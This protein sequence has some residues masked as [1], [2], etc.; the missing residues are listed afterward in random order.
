MISRMLGSGR[1]LHRGQQRWL[2]DEAGATS[3]AAS[4]VVTS[5]RRRPGST[6][7]PLACRLV[8]SGDPEA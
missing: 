2:Q 4:T 6:I 8:D 5:S 1:R 7:A 3:S